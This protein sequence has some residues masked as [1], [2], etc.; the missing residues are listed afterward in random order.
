VQSFSVACAVSQ[1]Q[2]IYPKYAKG[3]DNGSGL[4]KRNG[5]FPKTSA[6]RDHRRHARQFPPSLAAASTLPRNKGNGHEPAAGER[7]E[8][9]D[10]KPASLLLANSYSTT[11]EGSLPAVPSSF[12]TVA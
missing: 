1:T 4:K 10:N 5:H 9:F 3:R 11:A 8:F 2:W 12:D 7:S 6:A